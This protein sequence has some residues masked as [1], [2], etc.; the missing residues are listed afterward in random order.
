VAAKTR[1]AAPR[2]IK[3]KKRR[4]GKEG[5]SREWRRWKK[6]AVYIA[7]SG[8]RRMRGRTRWWRRVCSWRG[9]RGRGGG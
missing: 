7:S 9:G 4:E 1:G 8:E 5:I 3:S 6:V 2:T